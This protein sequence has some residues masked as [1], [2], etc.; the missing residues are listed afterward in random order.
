LPLSVATP[1]V[2][3]CPSVEIAGKVTVVPAPGE[4]NDEI[5]LPLSPTTA[6]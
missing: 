4:L 3:P 2:Q 5:A 1:S 6:L